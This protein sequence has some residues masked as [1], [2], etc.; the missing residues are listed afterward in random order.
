[1]KKPYMF[2]M[3]LGHHRTGAHIGKICGVVFAEN[4]QEAEN[5][6]W[7]KYGSDLAGGLWVEEVPESGTSFTVYKD[8][9]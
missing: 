9:I 3:T 7:E 1:M 2:G 4:I 6:A 5:I 8:T